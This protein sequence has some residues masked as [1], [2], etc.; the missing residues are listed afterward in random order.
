[1]LWRSIGAAL[2]TLLCLWPA[3]LDA[4]VAQSMGCHHNGTWYADRSLV[5]SVEKCLTC[6][7]QRKTLVCR[8]KV[9]PEMPMP[10][11]RGCIVVQQRNACC[12]Y[13]SCARLD[14]FYKIPAT[15]RIIA[16]LDHYERESIDRVVN[17]NMLQRRSDDSEVDMYVCVKNGTVYKSGSAMSSSNLCTYCYCIGGTEKCVKP[18]CM[19]PVEGCKPIFVDSTCCPVRYDCTSKP[20]GK[21]SQEV[22]YRKTSN[23]HYLRMSQRLQRNRGCTVN[24][25]FYVEGQKMR[26]DPDKPCDI[27]FCIRGTR[28]CA[29][30]KCSP[31]LKNCIPVV[32]KGQ[33]CPSSYD[34]G[35]QRAQSSRQFNL[36]SLLFGKEDEVNGNDTKKIPAEYPPD[37]HPSVTVTHNQNIL[38]KNDE[39]SILDTIREGLEIID[40]NNDEVIAQNIDKLAAPTKVVTESQIST[41]STAPENAATEVS[42]LD[43]LL[44]NDEDELPTRVTE[45]VTPELKTTTGYD[46]LS[47]V[48]ILLGPDEDEQK[49]TST[50]AGDRM[51]ISE[52]TTNYRNSLSGTSIDRIDQDFDDYSGSGEII[53]GESQS[54]ESSEGP[55]EE[56]AALHKHGINKEAL[57]TLQKPTLNTSTASNVVKS[58]EQTVAKTEA[59]RAAESTTAATTTSFATKTPQPTVPV[60]KTTPTSKT[61]QRPAIK[62][63]VKPTQSTIRPTLKPSQK[64]VELKFKPKSTQRPTEKLHKTTTARPLNITQV[65]LENTTE[66]KKNGL[67]TALLDGLSDMLNSESVFNAT[68]NKVSSKNTS[69]TSTTTKRP[70]DQI[71]LPTPKPKPMPS[72]K[73]LP[74]GK[75][76][77]IRINSKI[78]NL[79][80]T[81]EVVKTSIAP[82]VTAFKPLPE[83][84]FKSPVVLASTQAPATTTTTSHTST[85][86]TSTTTPKT[87]TTER[88]TSTTGSTTTMTTTT[89][90]TTTTSSTTSTVP[91]SSSVKPVLINTNPTILESD[92]FDANAEPT[93]P[94]SLPNLKIIPFLP[95][96]AVKA[97]RNKPLYDYYHSNAPTA[98]IDYDQYDEG[99]IYPAITEPHFPNYPDIVDGSKAEYIYKFNVEGP[100]PPVMSST[101]GKSDGSSGSAAA[102]VKYDFVGAPEEHKGFSPP[103]E[104][105]GGFVP[106]DPLGLSDANEQVD[107]LPYVEPSYQVTKHLI[108]IT[109]SE[110]LRDNTTKVIE[111]TTPDP[112]KDVIRTEQPPDLT[113]LI[114]DK[115]NILVQ[116]PIQLQPP[117]LFVDPENLSQSVIHIT[118]AVPQLANALD[119][120]QPLPTTFE[121][122]SIAQKD[123]RQPNEDHKNTIASFLDILLGG[124]P[125]LAQAHIANNLNASSSTVPPFKTLPQASLELLP[126]LATTSTTVKPKRVTPTTAK[127]PTKP[128][129]TNITKRITSTVKTNVIASTKLN[130]TVSTANNNTKTKPKPKTP[131]SHKS[132][133]GTTSTSIAA[134][135]S[136]TT[137][138]K[139]TRP[140]SGSTRRQTTKAPI[141]VAVSQ[142]RMN[143]TMPL[144]NPNNSVTTSAPPATSTH[145]MPPTNK[146]LQRSPFDTLPFMDTSFEVKR[147]TERPF[148]VGQHADGDLSGLLQYKNSLNQY[149]GLEPARGSS[150]QSASSFSGSVTEPT[151]TSTTTATN[152][153]LVQRNIEQIISAAA[154]APHALDAPTAANPLEVQHTAS[155][156]LIDATGALKLAGCNIYGRMYR[157]GRIILE[158]SSPCLECKCTEVGVKCGQLDC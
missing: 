65:E 60:K 21:S 6:Q 149:E 64:P 156:S 57:A 45:E 87:T 151:I 153:P 88:P 93:L 9:C 106:K 100:S 69:T 19:L 46:G 125:D 98:K 38:E 23:K 110:P 102:F 68:Q 122:S 142:K 72:F 139:S 127:V 5:P 25:Q 61:T 84:T 12:P 103:T 104:T 37:R 1:M 16:Y 66:K 154:S 52:T 78:A 11:P 76:S 123:S 70:K 35:S 114:E 24:K 101:A 55:L 120:E 97:D 119:D 94:P 4:F 58:P 116:K 44:G 91:P 54:G 111:I 95:T 29:P 128:T 75:P 49:Q 39:K 80:V 13:L 33:C 96:D 112:F 74:T 56:Y 8:L 22:R 15:R 77:H 99:S 131:A 40:G 118:T 14:A 86:V 27:C 36:F 138:P 48:D 34:C 85:S 108:D 146:P 51:G 63:S 90:S 79:T 152:V 67:L 31:A 129:A 89:T 145:S 59:N 10:P 50:T 137:R 144:R 73:P 157:V 20:S 147:T 26:S 107:A 130:G 41:Q 124:E 109:T 155:N 17:D 71:V 2:L 148:V 115:E 134:K 83:Q 32:P 143:G 132:N 53:V 121:E 141:A 3:Q 150:Q 42:F 82:N 117:K 133:A 136:S 126:D 140:K 43:L 135:I 92:P 18:K 105:E 47:W 7:C 158:L 81:P 113:S 28:R 30:K 62:T